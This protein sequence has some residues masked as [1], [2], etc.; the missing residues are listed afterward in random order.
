MGV[1]EVAH[2]FF[3]PEASAEAG[4]VAEGHGVS[5]AVVEAGHGFLRGEGH[6]LAAFAL[7]GDVAWLAF[8]GFEICVDAGV[9]VDREVEAAVDGDTVEDALAA[10]VGEGLL[11]GETALEM[12][13]V[14][15]H[16]VVVFAE[17]HG[18]AKEIVGDRNVGRGG[19]D[20]VGE[21][22]DADVLEEG[23]AARIVALEGEGAMVEDALEVGIGTEGRVG[24]DVVDDQHVVDANLDLLVADLDVHGEPFV[25]VDDLL[26]DIAHGVEGAGLLVVDFEGVGHLDFESC[27]GKTVL[28]VGGVE[29]DAGVGARAGHDVGRELEVFEVGVVQGAGV[30]EVGAGAVDLNTG[31]RRGRQRS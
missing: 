4:L 7:E 27:V 1:G 23:G 9:V 25:V 8:H 11:D 16:R 10:G 20:G 31:R 26:V 3:D 17:G 22:A 24:F 12:D 30:E 21:G 6:P 5:K 14:V 19:G 2:L 13:V 15:D 28:L 18:L 29:V